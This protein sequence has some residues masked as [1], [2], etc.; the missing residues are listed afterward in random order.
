MI[1]GRV[2][3]LQSQIT[4]L[5]DLKK[6]LELAPQSILD[7]CDDLYAEWQALQAV[8]VAAEGVATTAG[9]IALAARTAADAKWW[10]YWDCINSLMAQPATT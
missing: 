3:T 10:E 7:V 1:D 4:V 8:A 9:A 2:T 5:L 6:A